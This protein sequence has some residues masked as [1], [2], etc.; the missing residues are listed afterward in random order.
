[1]NKKIAGTIQ[2][3]FYG[4]VNFAAGVNG[5]QALVF[6][7]TTSYTKIAGLGK[8]C[9]SNPTRCTHGVTYSMMLNLDPSLSSTPRT[10]Y[11]LDIMGQDQSDAAGLYVFISNGQLGVYV[12]STYHTWHSIVSPV[13]GNWTHFAFVW[14]EQKGLVVYLDGQK[15]YVF[16]Y[17]IQ[18]SCPNMI[19]I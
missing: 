4:T 3:L 17:D 15:K 1:M 8:T 13:L 2:G 16:N 9:I 14:N 11:L 6:D 12:R 7:G 5:R 18:L 19:F 10:L